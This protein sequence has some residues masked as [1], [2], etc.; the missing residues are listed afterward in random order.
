[1]KDIEDLSIKD[2]TINIEGLDTMDIRPKINDVLY[3]LDANGKFY[4]IPQ[5]DD[6]YLYFYSSHKEGVFGEGWNIYLRGGGY[7]FSM[8]APKLIPKSDLK[9]GVNVIGFDWKIQGDGAF[10]S[11]FNIKKGNPVYEGGFNSILIEQI[12]GHFVPTKSILSW[13]EAKKEIDELLDGDYTLIPYLKPNPNK[14]INW[15]TKYPIK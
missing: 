6:S 3:L 11:Y 9:Y 4:Q 2:R 1:M 8:E 12:G 7:S 13:E 10:D 14:F 15:P 5:N